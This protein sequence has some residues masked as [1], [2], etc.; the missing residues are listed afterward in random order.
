MLECKD[1][2]TRSLFT[3][4]ADNKTMTQMYVSKFSQVVI[5]HIVPMKD[6]LIKNEEKL[7]GLAAITKSFNNHKIL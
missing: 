4:L 1:G 5:D 3:K 6:I 7:F 2:Q